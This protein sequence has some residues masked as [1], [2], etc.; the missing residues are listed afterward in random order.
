[1]ITFENG[2]T[3]ILDGIALKAYSGKSG[4]I[5]V[6][7][8]TDKIGGNWGNDGASA[9]I[10]ENTFWNGKSYESTIFKGALGGVNFSG[11]GGG[12]SSETVAM[13]V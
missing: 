9:F 13:V 7:I 2:N 8:G 12:S 5:G 10:Q 3:V 11:G 4:S 6:N 1:M